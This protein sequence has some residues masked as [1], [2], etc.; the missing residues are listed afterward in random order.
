MTI[1]TAGLMPLDTALQ[2]ILASSPAPRSSERIPLSRALGRI[3]AERIEAPIDVPW[4]A[5][6]A[7]DGYAL[8]FEDCSRQ[9]TFPVSQRIAAGDAPQPLAPNTAARVFTGSALPTGADTVV[10]Q[11]DC[12]RVGDA[13]RL[14]E[15]PNTKGANVRERGQDIGAG[16]E[17][18]PDGARL[19]PAQLGLLASVG[20]DSVV[21]WTR[22][23]VALLAT[24]TELTP[25]GRPLRPGQIYSSNAIVLSTLLERLGLPCLDL[26]V[27]PDDRDAT[28]DALR[29]ASDQAD[30][31]LTTGG[32]SVGEEDHVRP[33]VAALG[34]IDIWK[35]NLKPGKPFAFGRVGDKPF[36]GL[37]GNPVS[38]FVTFQLLV[39]PFLLKLMGCRE[40]ELPRLRARAA[41]AW[42]RPGKREEFL[43]GR[44]DA[45]G[46]VIA[47]PNQSSGVLS[48]VA[49][50]NCLIEVMPN[51]PIAPGDTVSVLLL[52]SP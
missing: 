19:G 31:V 22:P 38:A 49:W 33:A 20:T 44:L 17:L 12:Q 48:S 40:I 24:G 23:T 14:L 16:E 41:F 47:Y 50:A 7:M 25:P 37:P 5:N 13:V 43:R 9:S 3:L 34:A 35:L 32:V 46:Q 26:G 39:R 10:I 42:P 1:E 28:R 51:S 21:A 4:A 2:R 8:R 29:A 27:V 36:L 18:V 6:S 11:E 45:Q 52:N 15:L 30:C